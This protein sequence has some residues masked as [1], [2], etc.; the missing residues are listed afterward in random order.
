MTLRQ[1]LNKKRIRKQRRNLVP[2]LNG[3]PYKRAT[4]LKLFI[5]KP[6][7]PNSAKRKVLQ[8]KIKET[9]KIIRCHIPGQGYTLNKNSLLLIRGGRAQDL[10]G[11]RYKPVRGKFDLLAVENR[12]TRK[13]KFGIK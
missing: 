8:A 2:A 4:V 12:V 10:I 13:T 7:K 5:E 9:E 1:V 3:C 6:K 11:F